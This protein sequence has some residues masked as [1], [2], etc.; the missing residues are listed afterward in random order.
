MEIYMKQRKLGL[1][2]HHIIPKHAGGT[3]DDENIVYLTLEEHIK[4]HEEL[5]EKYGMDADRRAIDLLKSGGDPNT[6]IMKQWRKE[7][8]AKAAKE[9]HK[10]KLEN[11]F[12]EKLGK[13]NSE[14]IK[15]T[16]NPNHSEKM[17]KFH[18]ENK[19]LWWNDGEQNK[20][21]PNCPGKN[22]IRGRLKK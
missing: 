11:G 8:N 1:H 6:T 15:G 9:A 18:A 19:Q 20:R 5:Y 17:K 7:N 16:K 10:V 14:R 2:R 12:Y 21:S 4:A 3:D 13:L 22:W